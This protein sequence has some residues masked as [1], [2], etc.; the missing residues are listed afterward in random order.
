MPAQSLRTSRPATVLIGGLAALLLAASAAA[1]VHHGNQARAATEALIAE[2]IAQ[3]NG[4]FCGNLGID[5]G[6]A[7][8]AECARGLM[9][10]RSRHQARTTRELFGAF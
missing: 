10:I 5:P 7:R 1:L 4:T 9:D 2:E 3:E 8:Y 6:M